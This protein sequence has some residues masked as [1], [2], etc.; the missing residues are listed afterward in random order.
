MQHQGIW[1]I[2]RKIFPKIKPSLPVA[3]KNIKNQLITNPEE[4]KKLYLETFK[5]RLRHRPAQPGFESLLDD[6]EELFK[7]RLEM[8]KEIKTED[9]K[10]KDLE[11]A[12]KELKTGKCRDPDVLIREIFKEEVI[13][14]DLKKSMIILLITSK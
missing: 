3:K 8:S 13:G 1:K 4:L 2:K 7:L 5:Y 11:D 9:W 6:Q 10:M 14:E 12:L